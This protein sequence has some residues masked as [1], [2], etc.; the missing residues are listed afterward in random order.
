MIGLD[1]HILYIANVN[2]RPITLLQLNKVYYFTLGFLIYNEYKELAEKE[3]EDSGMEHWAYG[4][5]VPS[6]FKKYKH[7]KSTPIFDEGSRQ[8]HFDN[9]DIN[10]AI[11]K[12]INTNSFILVRLNIKHVE[13]YNAPYKHKYDFRDLEL[14]FSEDG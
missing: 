3:F 2:N 4:A 14:Y 6:L 10:N 9:E 7:H 13:E 5:V 12:L 1:K 8:E 11:L